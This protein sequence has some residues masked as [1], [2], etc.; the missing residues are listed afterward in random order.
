MEYYYYYMNFSKDLQKYN[1]NSYMKLPN[2][3]LMDFSP[4]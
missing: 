3:Q 4:P 2:I 1:S